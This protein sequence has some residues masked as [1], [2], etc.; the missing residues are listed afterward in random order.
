MRK[1]VSVQYTLPL[2]VEAI[3]KGYLIYLLLAVARGFVRV[4]FPIYAEL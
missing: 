4:E 2:Y 1:H 3:Q